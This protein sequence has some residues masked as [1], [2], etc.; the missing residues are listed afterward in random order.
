MLLCVF[1][2]TCS[3]PLLSILKILDL[4][5]FIAAVLYVAS[6]SCASSRLRPEHFVP[7]LVHVAAKYGFGVCQSKGT[8]L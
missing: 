3:V 7:L 1:L 2:G 6:L 5:V 4:P 8:G